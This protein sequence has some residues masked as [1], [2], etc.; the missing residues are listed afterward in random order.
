MRRYKKVKTKGYNKRVT[1]GGKVIYN[2]V[3]TFMNTG[4]PRSK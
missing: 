3:N 4:G 2:I 1:S